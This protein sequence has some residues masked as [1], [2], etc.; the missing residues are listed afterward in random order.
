MT[1]TGSSKVEKLSEKRIKRRKNV[2]KSS[3][4]KS[5]IKEVMRMISS[6]LSI[7]QLIDL[8]VLSEVVTSAAQKR[9]RSHFAHLELDYIN[10]IEI[11]LNGQRMNVFDVMPTLEWLSENQGVGFQSVEFNEFPNNDELLGN[12]LKSVETI[13]TKPIYFTI[14]DDVMTISHS[15]LLMIC[16]EVEAENHQKLYELFGKCSRPKSLK[17]DLFSM[18][19]SEF[20]QKL[21]KNILNIV[22]P[23]QLD[24]VFAN[25][26]APNSP[27][28]F[29]Y[30]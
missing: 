22:N 18:A 30:Y 20:P 23:T 9:I 17:L 1:S 6:C 26:E 24:V 25:S 29:E 12:I 16:Q 28:T 8:S 11:M 13:S 15:N 4:W 27:K 2:K 21:L 10:P 5:K 7:S 3:D 19:T 14:V